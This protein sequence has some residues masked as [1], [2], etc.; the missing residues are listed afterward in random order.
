M[1]QLIK[2]TV[3]NQGCIIIPPE[4]QDRLGLSPGMV[5]VVEERDK[6]ELCLRVRQELPEIV[7]KQ[8]VLVVRAKA[9]G[10]LAD[11]VRNERDR[12]LSELN[13]KTGL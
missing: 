10:D 2:V 7:D 8:G 6:G 4:I 1:R 11:V 3:D 5:L 13:R 9:V 12:R